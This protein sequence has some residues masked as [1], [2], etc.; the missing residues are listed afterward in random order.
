MFS[1][2][3]ISTVYVGMIIFV[4]IAFIIEIAQKKE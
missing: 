1:L 3:P 2:G 4:I